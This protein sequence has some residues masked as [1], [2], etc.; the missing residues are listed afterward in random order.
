VT[1]LDRAEQVV[2]A[3]AATRRRDD[4]TAQDRLDLL[5]RA[6]ESQIRQAVSDA[7]AAVMVAAAD[8]AKRRRA[9]KDMLKWLGDAVAGPTRLRSVARYLEMQP[10]AGLSGAVERARGRRAKEVA[11]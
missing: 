10:A 8:Y 6:V 3:Y 7:A 11:A 1:P 5:Q 9:E 2:C 4:L